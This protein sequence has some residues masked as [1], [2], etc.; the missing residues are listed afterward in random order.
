MRTALIVV[1]TATNALGAITICGS[2]ENDLVHALPAEEVRRCNSAAEAIE[3][4]EEGSAVMVLAGSYPQKRTELPK[5]F[6]RRARAKRLR[7][8]VEYPASL[9]GVALPE[10]RKVTWER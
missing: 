7:L 1:L 3:R 8:Y 4:A 9:E 5:D 6:L 10:E 2:G